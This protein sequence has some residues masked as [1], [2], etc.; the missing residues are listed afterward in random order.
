META[1]E[2]V[3]RRLPGLVSRWWTASAGQLHQTIEDISDE[4]ARGHPQQRFLHR[5]VSLNLTC[6]EGKGDAFVSTGST[7]ARS[8]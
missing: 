7:G 3:A 4:P 8:M 2:L 6:W 1:R 5:M